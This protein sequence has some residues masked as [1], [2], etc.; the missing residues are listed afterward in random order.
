MFLILYMKKFH[1]KR[2]FIVFS[3]KVFYNHANALLRCIEKAEKKSAFGME[4]H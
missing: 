2:V 4:D 1:F 3:K